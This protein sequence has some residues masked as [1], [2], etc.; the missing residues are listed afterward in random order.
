MFCEEAKVATPMLSQQE[1]ENL[2]D[3]LLERLEQA[4]DGRE[5]VRE[6]GESHSSQ[7]AVEGTVKFSHGR[8]ANSQIGPAS[9][10]DHFTGGQQEVRMLEND[11]DTHEKYQLIQTDFI[12]PG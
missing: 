1:F 7:E 12:R 8:L 11:A 4:E 10:T 3:A 2:Y 9:G 6:P 5:H